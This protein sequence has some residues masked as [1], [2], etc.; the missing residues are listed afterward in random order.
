MLINE[1]NQASTESHHHKRRGRELEASA[2]LK[3]QL[4]A[5]TTGVRKAGGKLVRSVTLVQ[6]GRNGDRN[7]TSSASL[8]Q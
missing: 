3:L 7:D 8:V 4:G 6:Y 5:A 2:R 1:A